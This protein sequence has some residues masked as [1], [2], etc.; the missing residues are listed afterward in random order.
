MKNDRRF[1]VLKYRFGKDH[2][3]ETLLNGVVGIPAYKKGNRA[4]PSGKTGFERATSEKPLYYIL[5]DVTTKM[6]RGVGS[7]L[8]TAF[9]TDDTEAFQ[10]DN[11]VPQENWGHR[12]HG[13]TMINDKRAI[14]R[15]AFKEL[16]GKLGQGAAA[17]VTEEVWLQVKN[18]MIA[19]G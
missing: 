1:I 18:H 12:I 17:Y 3:M 7:S 4:G 5:Y 14:T 13:M 10:P 11:E 15:D 16:G 19:T 8:G 9:F 6:I 2:I